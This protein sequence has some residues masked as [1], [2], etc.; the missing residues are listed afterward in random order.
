[1]RACFR[2]EGIVFFFRGPTK[3]PPSFSRIRGQERA[4]PEWFSFSSPAQ[5]R[6]RDFFPPKPPRR[7]RP[8]SLT[9]APLPF[10]H[11]WE[12][13]L[14]LFPSP[15]HRERTQFVF[16]GE[17]SLR[18]LVFSRKAP[19]FFRGRRAG[20]KDRVFPFLLPKKVTSSPFS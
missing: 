11:P 20:P 6:I 15:R 16:A 9:D 1:V 8:S 18:P 19:V 13:L 12:I 14:S 4:L 2:P 5:Q 10:P 7:R 3:D 17:R